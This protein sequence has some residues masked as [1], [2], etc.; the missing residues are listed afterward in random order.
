MDKHEIFSGICVAIFTAVAAFFDST[1]SYLVALFAGFIFN[2]LA[3]FRA[4]EVKIEIR[5]IIPPVLLKNFSGNKFK[6]SLLELLLITSITYFLKGIAD[7]MHYEE[8]SSYVV[9]F[10][11][12]IAL[13][14]YI[15]NGLR[16]LNKGYPKVKFIT[17]MYYLLA[18]KFRQIFGSDVADIVDKAEENNK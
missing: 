1:L 11:I 5:R 10:L 17:M 18:F 12:A 4:D 8:S 6:D 15:R 16:N 3:G 14:Y 9:Q 7:L 2:I 13:Y